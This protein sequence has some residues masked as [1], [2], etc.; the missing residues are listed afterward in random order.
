MLFK[1]LCFSFWLQAKYTSPQT[2]TNIYT[3]TIALCAIYWVH[4]YIKVHSKFSHSFPY[5]L[6][7]LPGKGE[8]GLPKLSLLSKKVPERGLALTN[9]A[10]CVTNIHDLLL[11][12]APGGTAIYGYIGL[13]RCKLKVWFS[14]SL[15]W[16]RVYKSASL[17]VE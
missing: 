14:S 11:E 1:T 12:N 17:G 10:I 3:R 13:C 15:L 2:Q 5:F 16:D 7:V 6:F 4:D 8:D 9:T